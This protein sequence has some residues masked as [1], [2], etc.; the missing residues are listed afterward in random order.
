MSKKTAKVKNIKQ[1]LIAVCVVVFSILVGILFY[2][3]IVDLG[4]REFSIISEA[5]DTDGFEFKTGEILVQEFE[6]TIPEITSFAI[7]IEG[8]QP[9]LDNFAVNMTIYDANDQVVINKFFNELDIRNL[10]Q[11]L[12]YFEEPINPGRYKVVLE[13]SHT[14]NENA[15]IVLS[16]GGVVE[17]SNCYMNGEEVEWTLVM[18]ERNWVWSHDLYKTMCATITV[19][20]C[21]GVIAL[22][23]MIFIKKAAFHWCYLCVGLLFGIIFMFMI[24][25]YSTP[26]EQTHISTSLYLSD[27]VFGWTELT[28][29]N[30]TFIA[31]HTEVH[32]GLN[33]YLSRDTY[34]SFLNN[35]VTPLT[36][37]TAQLVEYGHEFAAPYALYTI[38]AIGITIG[39]ILNL[40]GVSTILLGTFCNML[41]FVLLA[42]Y[43]IKKVPFGK[44]IMAGVCLLPISLQQISSFSYDN[45]LIAATLIVI[46]LGLR[47]CY[48]DERPKKNEL[49]LYTIA[50]IVLLL[51]KG[52]VYFMIIFLPVFYKCSKDKFKMLW[53]KYRIQLIIFC[54]GSVL[55]FFRSKIM[56][57]IEGLFTTQEAV[58]ES[59]N[60]GV[61]IIK[62]TGTEGY[63]VMELIMNPL[64]LI[65]MI[66]NTLIQNVD[67]YFSSAIGKS[68]GWL[69][70]ET[71]PWLII[72]VFMFVLLLATIKP[73]Q[74]SGELIL[75]DK[76]IVNGF[77]VISCG[78]C[79]AAMLI[80]WT[81]KLFNTIVGVQGR[82]FLPP[83]IASLFTLRTSKLQISR[84]IDRELLYVM[85][86]LN[87]GVVYYVLSFSIF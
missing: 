46:A 18:Q 14:G 32:N 67:W 74:E 36:E 12:V 19:A 24:P 6:M 70:I 57:I 22:Y 27:F 11:L 83:I 10:C 58:V 44:M 49:V 17:G 37:E 85:F 71:I 63:T 55:I 20:L 35:L 21:V 80:L 77:S 28:D 52:G 26:D 23:Y 33:A 30:A 64:M 73:E 39:R 59:T 68:L 25:P 16:E 2:T 51:G 29:E 72:F 53:D 38:P 75:R 66:F 69:Q 87:I 43:A 9:N 4:E 50:S 5:A 47:W 45:P 13:A 79:L 65:K 34:R 42:T 56:A 86:I 54:I 7:S 78:L 41:S 60:T 61:N 48:A 84:N 15:A 62:W 82:Y 31:R 40:N 81:P 1:L 76:L 8:P 3:K